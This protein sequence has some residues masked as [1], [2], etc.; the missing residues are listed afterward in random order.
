[1]RHNLVGVAVFM[2][3]V[4]TC[5]VSFA[6]EIGETVTFIIPIDANQPDPPVG[7]VDKLIITGG[8]ITTTD[9][10]GCAVGSRPV[11]NAVLV[12]PDGGKSG[13]LTGVILVSHSEAVRPGTRL[14]NLVHQ[15]S[16]ESGG[17]VYNRYQG[18]V[19]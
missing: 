12:D 8:H 10:P 13:R 14:T 19:E 6:L 4:L 3:T 9:V 15:T 11:Q 1:M 18:T 7:R 2:S 5:S 17:I 16:C